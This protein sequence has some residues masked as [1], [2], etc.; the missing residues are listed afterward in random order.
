MLTGEESGHIMNI[1]WPRPRPCS[2]NSSSNSVLSTDAFEPYNIR[3]GSLTNVIFSFGV[4]GQCDCIGPNTRKIFS[5][6]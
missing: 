3:L 6:L 1:S 5:S 4:W 2:S